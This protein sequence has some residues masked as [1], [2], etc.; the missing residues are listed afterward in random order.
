MCEMYVCFNRWFLQHRWFEPHILF[1][2][3]PITMPL[4]L[5]LFI[6]GSMLQTCVVIPE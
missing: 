3:D 1:I 4:V 5:F 6:H 2:I